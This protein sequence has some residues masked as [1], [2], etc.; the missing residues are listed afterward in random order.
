M[1]SF[2]DCSFKQLVT[3]I[4]K[5]GFYD[6][7][8]TAYGADLVA[9]LEAKELLERGKITTSCCPSFV[10]YIKKAMPEY[11]NLISSTLSPMATLAE[12][13]KSQ[14]SAAKVVF[15][16]PC[17]SKKY[18]IKTKHVGGRVDLTLTFEELDAMFAAK[19]IEPATQEETEFNFVAS[20]SG[21]G[22]ASAGGVLA[23]LTEEVAKID[24]N[25]E[26]KAMNVSGIINFKQAIMKFASSDEFN[27]LEGMACEGGCVAGP[28]VIVNPN[29]A[30][31]QLN[32]YV[33]DGNQNMVDGHPEKCSVLEQ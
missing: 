13:I 18:E 16:G 9:K 7:V 22:F 21:R 28:G 6:V 17:T 31:A 25:F 15:I 5:L 20:K 29:I 3:S 11:S 10:S 19:E 8:E 27:V 14:D 4:K 33:A 2:R 24:P 30:I 12:F 1:S 32:K 23:A 26:V